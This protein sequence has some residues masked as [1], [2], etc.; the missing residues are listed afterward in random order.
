MPKISVIVPVYNVEKYLNTCIESIICQSFSDFELI[1][2]DDESPDQCPFIC[3]E[4][5]LKDPRIRVIHKK[6]GGLSDAR[7]AGFEESSGEW[8]TFIDSDDAVRP[9]F[10]SYLYRL[11]QT[12]N[13]KISVCSALSCPEDAPIPEETVAA[14][15]EKTYTTDDALSALF[16]YEIIPNAWAKLYH[17]SVFLNDIRYPKGRINEDLYTTYLLFSNASHVV[18]GTRSLYLYTV[19]SSSIMGTCRTRIHPD[20]LDGNMII[21]EWI[22]KN[23]PHLIQYHLK[24]CYMGF[25][26]DAFKIAS[27]GTE[28]ENKSFY[29]GYRVFAARYAR[30]LPGHRK[31]KIFMWIISVCPS[32]LHWRQKLLKRL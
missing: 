16:L 25:V 19:R 8:I 23:K 28:K 20:K 29:K 17:R 6:N 4:W 11:S 26:S 3:D 21:C 22:L 31:E 24:G 5:A 14:Y 10:L 18:V 32:L 7:N 1:L 27:A 13:A 15:S 12:N 2:V 9:D 30:L